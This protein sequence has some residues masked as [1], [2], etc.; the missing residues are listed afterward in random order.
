MKWDMHIYNPKTQKTKTIVVDYPK[1]T[2]AD[3][4]A[5]ARVYAHDVGIKA[6]HV[7]AMPHKS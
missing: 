1:T 4:G 2:K 5:V 3:Q 6:D 7:L